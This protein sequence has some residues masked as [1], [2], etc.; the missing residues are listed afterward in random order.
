MVLKTKAKRFC[1][2]CNKKRTFKVVDF[3]NDIEKGYFTVIY[4][5]SYCGEKQ[6]EIN[7]IKGIIEA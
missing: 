1:K 4:E 3:T 5:C 7:K 6:I 2:T